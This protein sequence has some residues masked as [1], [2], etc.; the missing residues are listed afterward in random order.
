[1]TR[2]MLPEENVIHLFHSVDRNSSGEV[3]I[4]GFIRYDIFFIML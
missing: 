1:M 2:D 4:H 3:D